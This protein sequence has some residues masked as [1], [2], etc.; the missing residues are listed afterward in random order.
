MME[1]WV[2]SLDL[3]GT[4]I[5]TARLNHSLDIVERYETL[6]GANEG[7]EA[8][9]A[10]IID[11]L[12]KV[13]PVDRS[14]VQGIGVSA[15]GPL[16]PSAGVLVAPPNLPGWLNVPLADILCK[17]FGLPVYCGN[18][19]NVAALAEAARGAAY[20]YRYVIYITV[21]TGIGSGII[22]DGVLLLGK[23][24]LAAEV[25]HIPLVIGSRVTSLE[26]EAAGPALARRVKEQ[27][28][29]GAASKMSA[30][31]DDIEAID[32]RVIGIAA[33]EGDP[34][35]LEAVEYCGFCVG[36]GVVT[37]LHLFNPEIVVIGGGVSNIG[38]LL[39]NKIRATVE[40]HALTDA[41]W[42]E[43]QIVPAGL[44]GDVSIVGAGALVLTGG[45]QKDVTQ[46]ITIVNE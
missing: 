36:L 3:G 40:T 1:K 39:F 20:G 24:G 27:I 17:E 25:G 28:R 18:D 2:V 29:Q 14:T 30:M 44:G 6:T 8:S 11:A 46:V 23:R 42:R 19:A 21:S 26:R 15:P 37:L 12:H 34:I 4:R 7:Y 43:L 35:A 38:A 22:N 13:M 5:R 16:D 45:G 10:R 41:Y 31:V 32:A 33:H 9:M